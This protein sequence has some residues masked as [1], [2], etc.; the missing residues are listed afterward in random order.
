MQMLEWLAS[1]EASTDLPRHFS[2]VPFL[3]MKQD[4]KGVRRLLVEKGVHL[5]DIRLM[6]QQAGAKAGTVDEEQLET[7]FFNRMNVSCVSRL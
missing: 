5:D 4:L 2:D 7:N 6:S 1:G 3:P